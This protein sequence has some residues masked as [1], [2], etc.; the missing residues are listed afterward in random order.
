DELFRGTNTVD[1]V[2]AGS[3]FLRAL[4][5]EGAFVVAATHDAEL[6]GLLDGEYQPHYFQEVVAGANLEFD[7]TLH[8]GAVAPRNALAVLAMV[9]FP[10]AVIADARAH[11]AARPTP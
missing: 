7:Y 8:E 10:A 5:R 4:R 11:A 6:I 2:A 3:A 9:G 1:R